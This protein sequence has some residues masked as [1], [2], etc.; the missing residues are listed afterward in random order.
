MPKSLRLS[1]VVVVL[2]AAAC[3]AP[4]TSTGSEPPVLANPNADAGPLVA[5]FFDLIKAHDADGLRG[6]LSPA[7]QVE[8]ADG[9]G[10]DKDEFLGNL[11]TINSYSLSA[12]EATQNGPVLVVRYLADVEGVVNGKSYTPGPAPRLSVFGWNGSGWQLAGH[13]NFNALGGASPSP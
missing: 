12:M 6:Y 7:F 11:P 10:V 4:P 9:T 3:S 1:F 5:R 2:V 8:R 13:A